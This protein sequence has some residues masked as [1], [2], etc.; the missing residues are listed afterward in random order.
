MGL[1]LHAPIRPIE[2][3]R[4]WF[5]PLGPRGLRVIGIHTPPVPE[6]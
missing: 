6:D 5:E 1:R 4:R 3:V 2:P